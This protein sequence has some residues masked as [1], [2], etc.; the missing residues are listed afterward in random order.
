MME[1]GEGNWFGKLEMFL[2]KLG[3]RLRIAWLY[4]LARAD[5]EQ[6]ERVREWLSVLR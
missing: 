3:L 6:R 1:E 2:L 5:D 4:R